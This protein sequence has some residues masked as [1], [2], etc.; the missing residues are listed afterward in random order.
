MRTRERAGQDSIANAAPA[1]HSA[2]MPIPNRARTMNR[3]EKLGEK[4]AMKLQIEYH[5]MEI[6]NGGRR[7]IRS[8]SQ[9]EVVAPRRRMIKVNEKIAVTSIRGTPNSWAI[10][11]MIRRKTVKSKA[12]SVHP[13]HAAQ[14]AYHWSLVGSFHHGRVAV[15]LY[16]D[17]FEPP[18]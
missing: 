5:R 4:P 11:P 3:K 17:I 15:G 2:P 14:N 13:S 9:P 8:D 16:P 12:S 7:P 18:G 1:G 10:G 6:T